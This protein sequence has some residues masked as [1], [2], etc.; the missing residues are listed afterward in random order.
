[1]ALTVRRIVTKEIGPR[2]RFWGRQ[3]LPRYDGL[4]LSLRPGA[5]AALD[6]FM[7]RQLITRRT[8]IRSSE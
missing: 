6:V 4:S 7:S 3:D 5:A 1:L 8:V 2:R